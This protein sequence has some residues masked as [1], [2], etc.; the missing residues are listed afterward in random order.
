MILLPESRPTYAIPPGYGFHRLTV[1]ELRERAG[2]R[3][4][5]NTLQIWQLPRRGHRY[6]LG[7][8]IS[9]G[10]GQDRSVCDVIRV[11]TIT[12]PEEQVAQFITDDAGPKEFAYILD[13]IGHLYT[14]PDGREAMA[15]IE[16]NNHGLSCQDTLQLHLGYRHFYIWEVLDQAD[17]AKRWTTRMGWVT[18]PKTRPILLDQ[19]HTAVTA[20]DPITGFS[21]LRIN[22]QFTLDEM[23]DFRTDGALWEAEAAKGAHDDCIIAGGIGHYVAW[24]IMGGESEPLA[25]RRQRRHQEEL[26]RKRQAE[27]QGIGLQLP[28]YR[29]TDNTAQQQVAQEALSADERLRQD[30][31]DAEWLYYDSDSRGHAGTLY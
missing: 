3:A 28:D 8:D 20:I 22:S 30:E 27:Q 19:F 18:T 7:A 11:G 17:P 25:D 23:R 4:L 24:R 9:D 15:A 21:E 13:A 31:E 12:E 1:P 29:N 6:I 14:W 2:S 16:C 5:F 10:L 26:R